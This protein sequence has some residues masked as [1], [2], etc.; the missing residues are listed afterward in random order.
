MFNCLIL[1]LIYS[2]LLQEKQLLS[3]LKDMY[4]AGTE[5][6]ASVVGWCVLGFLHYPEYQGRI[7]KEIDSVVGKKK[8]LLI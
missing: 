1:N 6:S 2:I 8:L 7:R 4:I 5:T 3:Y